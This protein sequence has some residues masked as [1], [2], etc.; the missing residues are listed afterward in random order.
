MRHVRYERVRSVFKRLLSYGTTLGRRKRL[1]LRYF[2]AVGRDDEPE[3]VDTRNTPSSSSSTTPNVVRKRTAAR[4]S[5]IAYE[6]DSFHAVCN[7]SERRCSGFV[8]AARRPRRIARPCVKR[9][10]FS[11]WARVLTRR[12]PLSIIDETFAE[13]F[14]ATPKRV[15]PFR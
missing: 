14:H 1:L 9:L 5:S 4:V 2:S 7:F 13:L 12:L 3:I 10:R 15:G 6:T 8:S 11:H